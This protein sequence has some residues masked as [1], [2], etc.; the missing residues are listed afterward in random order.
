MWTR[1]I[2]ERLQQYKLTPI[3]WLVL[4]E[5]QSDK[6]QI[7]D[8][9]SSCYKDWVFIP[10]SLNNKKGYVYFSPAKNRFNDFP[11]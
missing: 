9:F 8:N 2:C 5:E 3:K 6:T 7:Y 11:G 1:N 4:E 10:Q